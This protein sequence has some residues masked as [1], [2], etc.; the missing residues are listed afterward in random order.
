M[1]AIVPGISFIQT[2]GSLEARLQGLM[3]GFKAHEHADAVLFDSWEM[4]DGTMRALGLL[5]AMFQSLR[6]G[7][8]VRLIGVEEPETGLHP[9]AVGV[10]LGA[11]REASTRT[12]ILVTS[13]SPELLDDKYISDD[14]LLAVVAER[15]ETR[16]GP[17]DEA[18][19][20]A[21]KDRLY[22][23]GELLRINQ[24]H[25]AEDAPRPGPQGLRLFDLE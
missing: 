8:P 13:H 12:Q 1:A 7:S 23:A 3:F 11:L 24:L 14:E 16:L 25:L 2:A 17:I 22:T 9:F 6:P 20:S 21:I 10:L 19:R 4:S 15:G 18:G 5:V